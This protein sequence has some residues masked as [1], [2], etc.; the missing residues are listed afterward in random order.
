[1]ASLDNEVTTLVLDLHVAATPQGMD[2][3]H[4]ALGECWLTLDQTRDLEQRWQAE[5]SLAVAE[6]A[7]NIIQHAQNPGRPLVEFT[8]QLTRYPDRLAA[9]F[10]DRG[11]T[12]APP[13]TPVMPSVEIS[14]NELGERGRGL[15][16]VQMTTDYFLYRRTPAGEN[17][18]L[19]EKNFPA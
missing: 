7:S 14:Y 1:M 18:W 13:A 2:A 8:L 10:V 5:F 19:I 17:I 11:V 12:A 16:L 4:G 15:A 6:V 9:R 3:I